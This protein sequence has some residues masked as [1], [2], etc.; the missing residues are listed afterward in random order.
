MILTQLNGFSKNNDV[1]GLMT[2]DSTPLP[3]AISRQEITDRLLMTIQVS[4]FGDRDFLKPSIQNLLNYE[5]LPTE[6]S[7]R[8][9]FE[10]RLPRSEASA[11]FRQ[12]FHS[13]FEPRYT[14][15][16]LRYA[17]F[18]PYLPIEIEDRFIFNVFNS[19]LDQ[20]MRHIVISVD[21]AT[22]RLFH[23]RY[24]FD[25]YRELPIPHEG[26]KE[27]LYYLDTDSPR[28]FT[29]YYALKKNAKK[30]DVLMEAP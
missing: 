23:R 19:I 15:E 13:R 16:I 1:F 14:C 6:N 11:E 12:K 21:A 3:V 22:G 4:Y 25:P 20:G 24:G 28:F 10:F 18:D 17:S 5:I 27:Y 30:V 29:A 8:F 7:D 9:P 26:V 2:Y